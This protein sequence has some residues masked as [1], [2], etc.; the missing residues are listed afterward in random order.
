MCTLTRD[1]V[2]FLEEAIFFINF[3]PLRGAVQEPITLVRFDYRREFKEVVKCLR[4][5]NGVRI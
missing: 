2:Q 3:L 4:K 5:Q 1:W